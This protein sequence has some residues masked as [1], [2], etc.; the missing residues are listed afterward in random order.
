MVAVS[1]HRSNVLDRIFAW[2]H[3]RNG[4]EY[5]GIAAD[6]KSN[7]RI[8]GYVPPDVPLDHGQLSRLAEYHEQKW[9]QHMHMGDPDN[10]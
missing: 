10:G 7:G 1:H 3:K 5:R 6:L 8:S 4:Q 2:W 9:R